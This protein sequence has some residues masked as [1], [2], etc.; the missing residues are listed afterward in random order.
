MSEFRSLRL[1]YVTSRF[2]FGEGEAFFAPELK[3]LGRQVAQLWVVPMR[4]QG[5]VLHEDAEPL[6][7]RTVSAGL[8]SR[9]VLVAATRHV[10]A[11]PRRTGIALSHMRRSRPRVLAKNLAIVPKSL[12]FARALERLEIDHVHVQWG[13]ASSTMAML[14]AERAG[15]PWSLTLHRWDITEDNLLAD[16][17]CSAAFVRV[18]SE[19]GARQVRDLVPGARLDVLHL[20]VDVPPE[21]LELSRRGPEEPFRLLAVGSLTPQKGHTLLLDA[22]ARV[23]GTRVTLDIA[24]AGP[25][26]D[27]LTARAQALGIANRVRFLGVVPHATL[28]RRVHAGEW[29]ALVHTSPEGPGFSEGIPV[30]L[31]E[32]MA[33]GLPVIACPS[34]G[35]TELVRHGAGMLVPAHQPG[36]LAAA[37][38]KLAADSGLA[39]EL[40]TAGR[41]RICA[42]F[43]A[44]STAGLLLDR[45]VSPAR[46][47]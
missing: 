40:A 32:A 38:T 34:G 4:P 2:P 17:L 11:N 16:K 19:F 8:G 46:A 33:A 21:P 5:P 9:T 24:G 20:G 42:E 14:A 44:A 27:R 23:A 36:D 13:G 6:L 3:A 29:D 39:S 12:W 31:M 10:A 28:L 26:L 1:A 22:F 45:I 43:D 37:I 7:D 47:A 15:V 41:R 30:A 25:L 18:I 35:V